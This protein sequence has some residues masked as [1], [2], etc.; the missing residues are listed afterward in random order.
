MIRT[1]FRNASVL[2]L[3]MLIACGFGTTVREQ[4]HQTVPDAGSATVHVENT[5][6]SIDVTGWDKPTVDVRAEKSADSIQALHDVNVTVRRGSDGIHIETT[7]SGAIHQGGVRYTLSVP[8]GAPLDVRNDAGSV[9]ISGAR[10]NVD[11][12]TQAGSVTADLGT[13]AGGRN[14]SLTATTGSV[15]LS[16]SRNSSAKV[17]ARSSVG[18]IRSDFAGILP[19]RQNVVGSSASGSIGS[20]SARIRLSTTTGSITLAER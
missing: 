15:R 3:T 7:Y 17:D 12:R 11:A 19:S 10:G 20:G 18:S 4:V 1:T 16:M 2:A 14:V 8:A 6:G 5:A 13:I 9:T